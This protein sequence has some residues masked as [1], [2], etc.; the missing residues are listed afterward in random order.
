MLWRFFSLHLISHAFAHC[1]TPDSFPSEGKPMGV[2]T[3]KQA[4]AFVSAFSAYFSISPFIFR[5]VSTASATAI[6]MRDT[7]E[8]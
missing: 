7:S 2:P 5:R 1:A 8:I 3:R 6:P 4:T